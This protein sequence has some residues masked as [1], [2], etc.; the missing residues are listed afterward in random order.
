MH[1]SELAIY[2]LNKEEFPQLGFECSL[3]GDV[4]SVTAIP[5]DVSWSDAE[6][7]F[8]ELLSQMDELKMS[9]M[10]EKK[11]RLLYTISCKA[12]IKANMKVSD[13]EMQTLVRKVFA[14]ENINTC[15][16]GRPIV[17]SMTKKQIEKD[18]KRIV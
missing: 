15:P 7:L 12:A 11:E 16:H 3:D 14:L 1:P 5:T 10:S 4:L 8:I 18:F 13:L 9:I 2:E 17:I 6:P